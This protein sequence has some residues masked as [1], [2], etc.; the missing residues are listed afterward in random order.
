MPRPGT[1][2]PVLVGDAPA[3]TAILVSAGKRE[4]PFELDQLSPVG[5]RI[6]GELTLNIGQQIRILLTDKAGTVHEI[7][8]EV[9]NV[10]IAQ[11]LNDEADVRFL[12]VPEGVREYLAELARASEQAGQD[13]DQDNEQPTQR[14]SSPLLPML[15]DLDPPTLRKDRKK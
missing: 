7:E 6:R 4:V 5:G 11:L 15:D 1:P 14:R 2:T 9:V 3:S 10:H 8:A 12:K 13:F